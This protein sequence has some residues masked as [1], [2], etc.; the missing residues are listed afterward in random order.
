M[1][2]FP[3]LRQET[4]CQFTVANKEITI[5]KNLRKDKRTCTLAVAQGNF[6]YYAGFPLINSDGTAIGSLCVM[7]KN[8]KALK[9]RKIKMLKLIAKGIVEKL[10]V[11]RN[12]IKLI[13][14]INKSFKPAVC[15][16]INC[17]SGELAHLQSE[18]LKT[19]ETLEFQKKQLNVVNSNLSNF[20][21]RIAHDIKSPLKTINSFVQLI[22][23]KSNQGISEERKS[24][25][26]KFINTAVAE[27]TRMTDNLLRIA[28]LKSN[29]KPEKVSITDLI[30]NIEILLSDNLRIKNVRLIKPK[31]DIQVIGFRALLMQL[32]QNMISNGIKYSDPSKESFVKVNYDLLDSSVLVKISDNGIGISK[33]D[34]SSIFK[35]FERVSFSTDIEGF[36]IGLDTCKNIIEEM[37]SELKVDSELGIGTTFSFEIKTN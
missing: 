32:F 34:L 10:D 21:H 5:I 35:P 8:S 14:D 1:K 24:D 3:F 9:P 17:L 25:S 2:E 7:D 28:E 19:K 20:S 27:L 26:F 22:N 4:I 12:M 15:A 16:D 31:T 23:P 29:V 13:K 30:D 36:G 33:E 11:R 18:V 6:K 37:G